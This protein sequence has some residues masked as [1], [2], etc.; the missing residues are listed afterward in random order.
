MVRNTTNAL[1]TEPN[2]HHGN[3]EDS[4]STSAATT[5]SEPAN[6][7]S[8]PEYITAEENYQGNKTGYSNAETDP[9]TVPNTSGKTQTSRI[10]THK[11][12]SRNN[13]DHQQPNSSTHRPSGQEHAYPSERRSNLDPPDT[14]LGRR[15][16]LCK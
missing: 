13:P 9:T 6:T 15:L 5:D 2:T 16:T 14:Q 8:P 3:V 1:Q 11:R 10:W 12:Y 7:Q 4:G